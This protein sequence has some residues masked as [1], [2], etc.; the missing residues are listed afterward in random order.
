[1]VRFCELG[2]GTK[3]RGLDTPLLKA[4]L[5]ACPDDAPSRAIWRVLGNLDGQEI[6][7]FE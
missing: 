1:M 2:H 6:S 4:P 5:S 7:G 3:R